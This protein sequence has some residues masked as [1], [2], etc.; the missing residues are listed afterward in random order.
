MKGGIMKAIYF[1]VII[2][3]ASVAFAHEEVH[4]PEEIINDMMVQQGVSDMKQLDC[5]KIP[6]ADFEKLGDALMERM[7]SHDVHEQMDAMMGGEGSA[8]LQQMHIVM[9]RNWLS[10]NQGTMGQGMMGG[11][12]SSM[13]PMMMRMMGNY[14]PAFYSGYD[15]ALL[16]AVVGWVLFF[17][18]V[19]YLHSV[20]RKIRKKR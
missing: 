4:M 16:I 5:G 9:G 15:L 8:S 18:S 7:A 13:M 19:F 2:S 14:Y 1:F 12:P 17:I 20:K 10:C 3:L 11:M 6:D